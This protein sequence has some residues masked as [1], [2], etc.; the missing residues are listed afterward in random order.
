MKKLRNPSE[1]AVRQKKRIL[2]VLILLVS[3]S[4]IVYL[5]KK[6]GFDYYTREQVSTVASQK[7]VKKLPPEIKQALTITP[8]PQTYTVPVLLYHYVE[9]VQDKRDTIRKSLDVTPYTFEQQIITLQQAGYTFMT[10]RE[11][12]DVLDGKKAMPAKPILLTFDDGHWDFYTDV[13]PLLKKYQVKATAYIIPGFIG[14]ADFLSH[15]QLSEIAKSSLIDIGAHT[16]HHMWLRGMP[17]TR[18]QYEVQASKS[19]LE[20]DYH[21]KV[22]SFAY[23]YG[24]FDAQAETVVKN[25]GF[26]TAVAT[27]PGNTLNQANRYF[28]FRLHQGSLTGTSLLRYLQQATFVY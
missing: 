4:F 11:L 6:A 9:Y 22:V 13:Y 20:H 5:L 14:G 27:V 26:T 19:M 1:F 12:G 21:V 28:I 24:A 3:V 23:P 2:L 16:V 17:L 18:V 25:A 8:V 7:E 15:D 10:A